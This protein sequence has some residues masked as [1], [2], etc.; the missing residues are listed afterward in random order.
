MYDEYCSMAHDHP[1]FHLLSSVLRLALIPPS[2]LNPSPSALHLALSC[3]SSTPS[4]PRRRT[5]DVGLGAF[6]HAVPPN[7]RGSTD[8][9]GRRLRRWRRSKTTTTMR[10]R[11]RQRPSWRNRGGRTDRIGNFLGT[12]PLQRNEQC[13][14]DVPTCHSP[15]PTGTCCRGSGE[16]VK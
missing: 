15:C 16:E 10:R 6:V 13:K 5:E 8:R 4:V 3:P 1:S 9:P 11:P 14:S 7:K 2:T 12:S